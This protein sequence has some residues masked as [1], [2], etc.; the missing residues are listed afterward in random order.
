M[1]IIVLSIKGNGVKSILK[2]DITMNLFFWLPAMFILM[3]VLMALMILFIK[4]CEKI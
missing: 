3:I 2:E 4:A 1:S